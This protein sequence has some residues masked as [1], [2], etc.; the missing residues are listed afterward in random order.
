M[1]ELTDEI[2]AKL[3]EPSVI[4]AELL[5]KTT[6]VY[7]HLAGVLPNEEADRLNHILATLGELG[8][9]HAECH[10]VLM[11]LCGQDTTHTNQVHP[12]PS[13]VQVDS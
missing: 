1:R 3:H 7:R 9:L 8:H 10:T 2:A 12:Q 13:T 11:L 6:E 4:L 5:Q